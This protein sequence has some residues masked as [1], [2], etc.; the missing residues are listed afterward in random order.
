MEVPAVMEASVEVPKMEI[1]SVTL[2]HELT[3]EKFDSE[4][5]QEKWN[6]EDIDLGL[7][8]PLIEEAETLEYPIIPD[9]E[10]SNVKISKFPEVKITKKVIDPEPDISRINPNTESL[11][12]HPVANL[13]NKVQRNK[14]KR[15][16]KHQI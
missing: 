1:P 3:V 15:S 13:E 16:I 5:F 4:N 9:F 11:Y 6:Q 14:T 8:E 7:L 10:P 12:Y 2:A